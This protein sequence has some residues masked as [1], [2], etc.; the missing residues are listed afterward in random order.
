MG[1]S[2]SAIKNNLLEDILDPIR[3]FTDGPKRL[4]IAYGQPP[5]QNY[6]MLAVG[7][8]SPRFRL[9]QPSGMLSGA[10]RCGFQI[11]P[12]LPHPITLALHYLQI[13]GLEYTRGLGD[14]C[15]SCDAANA[16]PQCLPLR[17]M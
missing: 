4:C 11:C 6:R 9:V 7:G 12:A 5:S 3:H 2:R 1:L 10:G 16:Q 8:C 13:K 15:P 14:E 17:A